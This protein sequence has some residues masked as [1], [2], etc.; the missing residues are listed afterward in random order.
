MT[1]KILLIQPP[2]VQLNAPY[3]AIY[4]LRSFLENPP[5]AGEGAAL[6]YPPSRKVETRDHSIG[7]FERIFCPRGLQGIFADAGAALQDH[8]GKDYGGKDPRLL[9]TAQGFLSEQDRWIAAIDRLIAFLRGKDAEWGHFLALANGVLPGGPRFDACLE[10][11]GGNPLPD[12]A[13]LLATKLLEDLAGFIA[14]TLDP[15]FSL[16]RYSAAGSSPYRDFAQAEAAVEGYILKTFYR[17]LLEEEWDSLTPEIRAGTGGPDSPET[18]FFLGLSVPFPGCLAGALACADSARKRFGSRVRVIAG[19]GYVNTELRFI[20]DPAI[21]GYFDYLSFDRGYGSLRAILD[22]AAGAESPE[23]PIYKTIYLSDRGLAADPAIAGGDGPN[24]TA[25]GGDTPTLPARF[26]PYRRIDDEAASAVFPD[27]R[28]LDFSR[29]ILP[30]DNRNPMHRLWSG[31]RW[32][33]AYLAHGCYWHNCAFCD[34]T[35]DYIRAYR[36]TPVEDFFRYMLGQA[37]SAGCRGLHLVDEAAP[38]VSLFRLAELNREAGLPL[39]FWGNIRFE[40][41]FDPD[42]A[43]LLAAGGLVGVSAGI[44]I[45]GDRG[46][47]RI[48]KGINLEDTIRVCAAFKEAGILIHAYLIYGYWDEDEQEIIDSAEILRQLFAAGLLDSAFWHRFVLTR[49]SRLFAE[50]RRGL[51]PGLRPSGR[52]KTPKVFAL[53]DL[54]FQGEERF[55]KY[56][57]PLDRLLAAWMA[58]DSSDPVTGAFPFRVKKPQVAPDLTARFLDA[59]ARDRDKTRA[60]MPD[61]AGPSRIRFLGS[62]PLIVSQGRGLEL[63]WRWRLGEERLR[64]ANRET[65]EKLA[66]LLEAAS[67]GDGSEAEEFSG[68]LRAALGD[69]TAERAWKRLRNGGLVI[70]TVQKC[71]ILERQP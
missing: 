7:L 56:D 63:R 37:E 32:L 33:K 62:R 1:A 14:Y 19:G 23:T 9:E 55:A 5:A 4:Y 41:S 40:R 24:G 12:D 71:R 43:A 35:L 25:P 26:E 69:S 39:V 3:P 10:S 44:E 52:P 53:N 64:L 11:L 36:K 42:T 50:W 20:R 51:H 59:Y 6:S 22:R 21:F 66:S 67:R 47:A 38:P 31:G 58:G 46:F 28:G 2:F 29:Y 16:I 15:S 34:V 57:G 70:A 45:A 27:Y 30:V 48:G 54:S 17:P 61:P 65:A 13:P 68:A 8:A 18:P 60:A 49:H